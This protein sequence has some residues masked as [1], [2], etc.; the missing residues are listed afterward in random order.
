MYLRE[1]LRIGV[2]R[3]VRRQIST[4]IYR[5]RI[6]PEGKRQGVEYPPAPSRPL[7]EK[8]SRGRAV[9]RSVVNEFDRWILELRQVAMDGLPS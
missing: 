1:C 6:F 5:G 4:I 3:S 2:G 8:E 9:A 7:Q